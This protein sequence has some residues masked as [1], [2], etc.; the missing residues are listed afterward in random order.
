MV[1]TGRGGSKLQSFYDFVGTVC[2]VRHNFAA[3]GT[4]NGISKN[5]TRQTSG[6]RVGDNDLRG[7]SSHR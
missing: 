7:V 3:H 2:K 5:C 6:V 4:W 1:E